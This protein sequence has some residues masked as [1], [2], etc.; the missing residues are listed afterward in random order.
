M[1]HSVKYHHEA[2]R[3]DD[4]E[5]YDVQPETERVEH[6]SN[7]DPGERIQFLVSVGQGGVVRL[8]PCAR[9]AHPGQGSDGDLEHSV[10]VLFGA[11]TPAGK[12]QHDVL[13]E[14]RQPMGHGFLVVPEVDVKGH[15]REDDREPVE[16]DEYADIDS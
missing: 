15:E 2:H 14:L 8:R 9:S 3:G 10:F 11:Q 13:G 1:Y 4:D 16:D 7:L 6:F 12:G 5:E